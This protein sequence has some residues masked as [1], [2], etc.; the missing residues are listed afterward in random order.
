[1]L[2]KPPQD[3]HC[4]GFVYGAPV[5]GW[6]PPNVP[7]QPLGFQAGECLVDLVDRQL[8]L[9]PQ[10]PDEAADVSGLRR[11]FASGTDGNSDDYGIGLSLACRVEDGTDIGG[12]P[13]TVDDASG[14]RRA[15]V[16]DSGSHADAPFSNVKG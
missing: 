6:L 9:P 7:Q 11:L 16:V 14:Q 1:M 10:G 15:E 4:G 12:Q 8:R 3:Q 5:P 2:I 13:G